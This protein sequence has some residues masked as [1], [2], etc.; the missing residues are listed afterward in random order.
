MAWLHGAERFPSGSAVFL[1]DGRGQRALVPD[2]AQ[3]ADPAV[4]FDGQRVLFAGKAHPADHWQ[5]WE[6]P[7]EGGAARKITL[8]NEDC[9][10][11]FYL[12][13]DRIVY[14]RSIDGRFVIEVM[15]L[16]G[17]KPTALTHSP[18]NTFP[19][20]VLRDGR[21]LFEAGYPLGTDTQPEIYTVYSD[22]SGVES[23]RCDHGVGRH[24]AKQTRS[25]DLIFS[26]S[27]TLARFTS[28]R[29]RQVPVAAPSGEYSGDFAEIA[30][31]DWLLSWRP[32][33]TA[34]FQLM[35]WK[36]GAETLQPV[37]VEP[38]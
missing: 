4:S 23:Y 30:P 7:L 38:R 32:N 22:G 34:S 3:S 25:G 5:I 35:N 31:G 18:A 36:Q 20:D 16:S 14:A 29:A 17:G 33:A 12:P 10:R 6:I 11:P 9:V 13:G 8:G 2:F 24:S 27:Q 28:A 19:T 26:S 1:S 21:I 15:D 37:L